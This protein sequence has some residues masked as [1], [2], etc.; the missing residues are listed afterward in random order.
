MVIANYVGENHTRVKQQIP[1]LQTNLLL[2]FSRDKSSLFILW[3]NSLRRAPGQK[4]QLPMIG[5]MASTYLALTMH[6]P[7][8]YRFRVCAGE[9]CFSRQRVRGWEE[10]SW[11]TESPVLPAVS[12]GATCLNLSPQLLSRALSPRATLFPRF[13]KTLP[14]LTPPGPEW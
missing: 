8:F 6:Q 11:G 9:F 2:V 12:A 3:R 1:L 10:R 4:T 7:R 14:L 13:E 5:M